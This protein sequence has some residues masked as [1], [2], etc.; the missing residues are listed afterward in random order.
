MQ[1]CHCPDLGPEYRCVPDHMHMYSGRMCPA[2]RVP[3]PKPTYTCL[4]PQMGPGPGMM[5]RKGVYLSI[6]PLRLCRKPFR[7][8]WSHST[9]AT[10][11]ETED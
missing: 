11:G 10:D 2:L 6:L 5:L 4:T 1:P 7:D 3:R 8:P 9:Q